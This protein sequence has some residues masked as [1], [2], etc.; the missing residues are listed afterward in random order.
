M[1]VPDIWPKA[2]IMAIIAMAKEIPI[3]N[4][5]AISIPTLKVLPGIDSVPWISRTVVTTDPVPKK[6]ST[7]VPI[8]SAMDLFNRPGSDIKS[9][10]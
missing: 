2:Y 9:P 6:T 3:A 1:C 10:A 8:S 7:Y 4:H 5:A